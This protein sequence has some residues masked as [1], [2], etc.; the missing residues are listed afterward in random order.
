MATRRSLLPLKIIGITVGVVLGLIVMALAALPC[1]L[2][3]P[4]PGKVLMRLAPRFVDAD[5]KVGDARLKVMSYPLVSLELDSLELTYPHGRFS[6]LAS[7][8]DEGRGEMADTLLSAGKVRLTADARAF[9]KHRE[10]D[11]SRALFS[12]VRVYLHRYDSTSANWMVLKDTPSDQGNTSSWAPAHVRIDT[13]VIGS[14][15]LVYADA[16]DTLA[17]TVALSAI[18]ASALY[19]PEADSA[20]VRAAV[21]IAELDLNALIHTLGASFF[22]EASRLSTDAMLSASASADGRVCLDSLSALLPMKV[23]AEIPDALV[24]YGDL[25]RDA[26]VAVSADAEHTAESRVNIHLGG[27]GVHLEGLDLDASGIAEDVLGTDP[28]YDLDACLKASLARLAEYLPPSMKDLR[29]SGNIDLDVSGRIRQS[30]MDIYRFA[31]S[32]IKGHLT[33]D[34]VR[35]DYPSQDIEAYVLAP[36]INL[37]TRKSVIDESGKQATLTAR[38]DSIDFDFGES[39]CAQG[40]GMSLFAQN[41][42]DTINSTFRYKPFSGKVKADRLFVRGSDSLGV[43]IADTD[44]LFTLTRGESNSQSVPHLKLVS[45]SG[46]LFLRSPLARVAMRD[47]SFTADAQTRGRARTAD[48]TAAGGWTRRRAHE[49]QTMDYLS[50]KEFSIADLDFRLDKSLS[51]LI[52]KWNPSLKFKVEQ[53]IVLSPLFPLRNRFTHLDGQFVKDV[54]TLDSLCLVSGSSDLVADARV[55]GLKRMMTRGGTITLD[56]ELESH[57]LNINEILTAIEITDTAMTESPAAV[58]DIALVDDATYEQAFE[59]GAGEMSSADTAAGPSYSLFIIPANLNATVTMSVDSL[60]YADM[61]LENAHARAEMKERCLQITNGHFETDMGN[62]FM[63]AFYSTKTKKDIKCGFDMLLS[64]VTAERVIQL[65]PAVDEVLPMLKSFKGT[66]DCS[67]AAT[68]Q[69]DTNMNI[70]VP[71]LNGMFKIKGEDLVLED[72]GSLKKLTS[73]LRFKDREKGRIDDMSVYGIVADNE[74]EVFPFILS[75]DRYVMALKG[76]QHFDSGFDYHVSVIKSPLPFKIGLNIF[77]DSFDNWK[78][79]I[80]KPQYKSTKVPLFTDQVDALQLNLA[81]S[82]REIFTRGVDRAVKDARM[83]QAAIARRKQEMD[84]S[85][86]DADLLSASEQNELESYMIA[87]EIEEE[88]EAINREIEELLKEL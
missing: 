58:P 85:N 46:R 73:T 12:D 61:L 62:A 71:T 56:A 59:A 18:R 22:A 84:Y 75:I 60:D 86:E 67:A 55:E 23:S 31:K 1:L 38:V 50:E 29:A 51:D 27:L 26:R 13:L 82:I 45:N 72:I 3:S 4:L 78:Y 63:S 32:D 47:A 49:T 76:L 79:R 20:Y 35:L 37:F 11:V 77:G 57:R 6:G 15:R 68:T 42:T 41:S 64:D 53:G 74:L 80:T 14:P 66:L 5:L 19:R 21:D 17:A 43:Y 54:L 9:L 39:F 36:D 33:G 40:S 30:Q 34:C 10:I 65:I 48:T 70:L 52:I 2:D 44:N 25:I 24:S 88:T 83:A 7:E 87:Q 16:V 81:T 69:L 28:L 8:D